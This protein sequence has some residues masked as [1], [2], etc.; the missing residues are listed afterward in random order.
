MVSVTTHRGIELVGFSG[1]DLEWM[2]KNI[3][4]ATLSE[5]YHNSA[6]PRCPI[7]HTLMISSS[8]LFADSFAPIG[9]QNNLLS[10][11]EARKQRPERIFMKYG[12]DRGFFFVQPGP[13]G[14][15]LM[16]DLYKETYSE[17]INLNPE[18]DW[19][20]SYI[21]AVRDS[22]STG[23][24]IPSE[25][26]E[27]GLKKIYGVQFKFTISD[28]DE[29]GRTDWPQLVEIRFYPPHPEY[30]FDFDKPPLRVITDK[31]KLSHFPFSPVISEWEEIG[32]Y[33]KTDPLTI[34]HKSL[35]EALLQTPAPIGK[36]AIN[37]IL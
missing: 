4:Y 34:V 33:S 12:D 30:K 20:V 26:L 6:D 18:I 2:R 5:Q 16:E 35:A 32:F 9:V 3:D 29:T 22:H 21:K 7:D 10:L 28:I 19:P 23:S 27:P 1:N 25:H 11:E 14:I 37:Q 36:E 31:E 13:E 15:S 17:K 8:G 24:P